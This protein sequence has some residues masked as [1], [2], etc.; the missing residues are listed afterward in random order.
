MHLTWSYTWER[1]TGCVSTHLLLKTPFTEI[2]MMYLLQTIY[3]NSLQWNS[4]CCCF[5][6]VPGQDWM[7]P[8]TTVLYKTLNVLAC[9]K[10]KWSTNRYYCSFSFL[11]VSYLSSL[12]WFAQMFMFFSGNKWP[13]KKKEESDRIF[14]RRLKENIFCPRCIG[15][16][17][18]SICLKRIKKIT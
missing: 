4:K 12:Y 6:R 16:I 1:D 18:F 11:T 3:K 10:Y 13:R 9:G 15:I 17:A 8:T 5:L 2:S 7:P 14:F